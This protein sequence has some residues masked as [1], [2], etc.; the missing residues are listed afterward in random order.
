[1]LLSFQ[2]VLWLHAEDLGS[3]SL[4]SC[5]LVLCTFDHN[6]CCCCCCYATLSVAI[7]EFQHPLPSRQ[8]ENF[9]SQVL[10]PFSLDDFYL[11]WSLFSDILLQA[12]R[13]SQETPST[14]CLEIFSA[15]YPSSFLMSSV[16]HITVRHNFAK[17]RYY[18]TWAF[19]HPISNNIYLAF[20]SELTPATCLTS[21]FLLFVH[22]DLGSFSKAIQDFSVKLLI[23]F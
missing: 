14:L 18:V 3:T 9:L 22:G 6:F 16:F 19:L 5:E 20:L 12:E 11:I 21:V 10:Y 4:I 1:M 23:S 15:K 7:S 8:D 13:R 17:F 2:E